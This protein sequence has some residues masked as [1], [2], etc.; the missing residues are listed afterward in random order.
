MLDD[1]N[2]GRCRHSVSLA[3]RQPSDMSG[4]PRTTAIPHRPEQ[5]APLR[6]ACTRGGSRRTPVFRY[7]RRAAVPRVADLSCAAAC[8]SSRYAT[9]AM[10]AVANVL[11]SCMVGSAA[12]AAAQGRHERRHAEHTGRLGIARRARRRPIEQRQRLPRDERPAALARVVVGRHAP[13]PTSRPIR[14]AARSARCP[15]CPAIARRRQRA[16]RAASLCAPGP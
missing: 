2:V 15:V 12:D 10:S 3:R 16:R 9:S 6:M 11:V 14:R 13:R 4:H 8:C 1:S 5:S 7:P